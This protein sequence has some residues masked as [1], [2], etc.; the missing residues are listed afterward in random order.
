[1]N[2]LPPSEKVRCAYYNAVI[3]GK[4]VKNI[5]IELQIL[6]PCQRQEFCERFLPEHFRN[7]TPSLSRESRPHG[8]AIACVSITTLTRMSR[9]RMP[10]IPPRREEV[11]VA[12]GMRASEGTRLATELGSVPLGPRRASACGA[13]AVPRDGDGN[14][15]GND[16]SPLGR[17]VSVCYLPSDAAGEPAPKRTRGYLK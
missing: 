7:A 2:Q 4:R 15:S 14:V 8:E 6:A 5:P 3:E 12:R 10:W 9:C 11:Q 17:S 16:A 1:M 13:T